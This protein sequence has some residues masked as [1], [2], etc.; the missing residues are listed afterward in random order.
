MLLTHNIKGIVSEYRPNIKSSDLNEKILTKR[1]ILKYQLFSNF[2]F[3][4]YA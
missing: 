2:A 1:A 4:N 3:T